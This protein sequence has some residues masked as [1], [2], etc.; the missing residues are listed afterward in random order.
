[1]KR[2][3]YEKPMMQVVELKQREPLLG[4]SASTTVSGSRG[5]EYGTPIDI[6]EN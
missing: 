5:D 3:E 4:T 6:W 2:K 1:M